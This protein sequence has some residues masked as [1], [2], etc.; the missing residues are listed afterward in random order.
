MR[1]GSYL[2]SKKLSN[3]ESTMNLVPLRE[4]SS[5]FLKCYNAVAHADAAREVDI[6]VEWPIVELNHKLLSGLFGDTGAYV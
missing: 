3:W 1:G 2:A 6:R 5:L 4:A